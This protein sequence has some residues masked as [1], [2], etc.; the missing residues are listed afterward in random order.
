MEREL[1]PEA[2][3][4][5]LEGLYERD[6]R[7]ELRQEGEFYPRS[8]KVD[9]YILSGHA[10][11][12]QSVEFDG[13]LWGTLEDIDEQA[14]DEDEAWAKIRAFYLDRGNLLLRLGAG[15]EWIFNESLARRIGLLS[16]DSH[17]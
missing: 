5:L 6:D 16:P 3:S 8:E 9:A 10:E 12:L 11:A 1:T 17:E 2:F 4:A 7:L 15:E 13:D 14:A